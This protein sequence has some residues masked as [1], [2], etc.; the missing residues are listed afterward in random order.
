MKKYATMVDTD[1][2]VFEVDS[3]FDDRGTLASRLVFC[4]TLDREELHGGKFDYMFKFHHDPALTWDDF[5]TLDLETSEQAKYILMDSKYFWAEDNF[6]ELVKQMFL[7][8]VIRR[9][10]L[11]SSTGVNMKLPL[12]SIQP[13]PK[14]QVNNLTNL[15]K[16]SL[17]NILRIILNNG[18]K[19]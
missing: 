5:N 3:S 6:K 18:G 7:M 13:P 2:R 15:G 16:H 12:F 19:R 17:K 4:K 10:T 14:N 9:K 11:C 1:I 8:Q